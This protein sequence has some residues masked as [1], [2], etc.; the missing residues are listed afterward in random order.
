MIDYNIE[1][2]NLYKESTKNIT[3]GDPELDM[4]EFIKWFNIDYDLYC[5]HT[6]LNSLCS[7]TWDYLAWLYG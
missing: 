1:L 6:N 5:K 4:K 3:H 7:L 2:Y